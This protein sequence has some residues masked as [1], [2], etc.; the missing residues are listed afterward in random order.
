MKDSALAVE[1]LH[2]DKCG[3]AVTL[4]DGSVSRCAH[5]GADVVVPEPH[6]LLRDAQLADEALRKRAEKLFVTLDRPPSTPLKIAVAIFDQPF[7]LFF[8]FFAI[9]IFVLSL[10]GTMWIELHVFG[11]DLFGPPGHGPDSAAGPT[12]MIFAQVM[13]LAFL[14]RAV[15]VYVHRAITSRAVLVTAL[16]VRPP[17]TPGG[18]AHCRE[19][20]APIDVA[21]EVLL[22]RCAYCRAENALRPRLRPV[23]KA[24]SALREG[25]EEAVT[26]HAEERKALWRKLLMQLF[27]YARRTGLVALLFVISSD[28]APRDDVAIRFLSSFA[29]VGLFFYWAFFS[30]SDEE[31]EDASARRSD[32]D[33]PGWARVLAGLTSGVVITYVALQLGG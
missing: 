33:L 22:V 24:V 2:C 15:G 26:R 8:F 3:A 14:P 17:L 29:V 23:Q 32:N 10:Q 20:G 9:P 6:R 5:C 28:L 19:C 25:V 18:P 27:R 16:A 1:V 31:K 7:L 4:G 21:P 11:V 30:R 12:L 13:L